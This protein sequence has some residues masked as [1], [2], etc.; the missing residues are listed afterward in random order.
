[1]KYIIL[2]FLYALGNQIEVQLIGTLS[3]TDIGVMI[4]FIINFF[5]GNVVKQIRHDKNILFITK[6]YILLLFIQFGAEILVN[7]DVQNM[8]KGFAITILSYMKILF[9]WPLVLRSSKNIFWLFFWTCLITMFF[10]TSEEEVSAADILSGEQY[11]FF[12]FTIAPL[13]GQF[14]VILSLW[15]KR[16]YDVFLFVF[17]GLLCIVLGARNVGL[18]IFLT[19]IISYYFLKNNQMKRSTMIKW[20]IIGGTICYGLF[21]IYVNAVLSGS[22]ISGNSSFQLKQSKDPYNPLYALLSG[23]T[24]SPA[25]LAAIYDSPWIGWGAWAKDPGW[26]YHKIQ[27]AFQGI[28][29]DFKKT[30]DINIIPAHSV[31]FQAGV[32]NGIFAMIVI[33]IIIFFFI[34]RGWFSLTRNNPYIFLVVYCIMQLIWNGF[35]SPLSHFR[36]SFPIYFICCLYSYEYVKNQLIKLQLAVNK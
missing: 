34:K 14:L 22:I 7:N 5:K 8:M 35:F 21:V 4:F 10:S 33:A 31:I 6:L 30:S 12:K 32:H 13:I 24:E 2:F 20:S 15:R 17:F 26:K 18:I 25:S 16:N 23:R 11:S 28:T 19:G 3:V 36:S 1:M 9:L 27:L 29:F